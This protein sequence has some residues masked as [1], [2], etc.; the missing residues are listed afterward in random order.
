MM[1]VEFIVSKASLSGAMGTEKYVLNRQPLECKGEEDS[2]K[3]KLMY[4]IL[5]NIYLCYS[6]F[7]LSNSI[8]TRC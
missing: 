4:I 7:N 2:K 6:Y 3:E 5:K 1:N 8:K